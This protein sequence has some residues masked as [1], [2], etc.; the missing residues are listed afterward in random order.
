MPVFGANKMMI[1]DD[2]DDDDIFHFSRLSEKQRKC[3]RCSKVIFHCLMI[4]SNIWI[5]SQF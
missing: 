1:D 4:P 5:L 3:L 2:G